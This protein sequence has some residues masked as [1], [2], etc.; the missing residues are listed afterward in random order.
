MGTIIV[1]CVDRD[2]GFW[3]RARK[4]ATHYILK[5]RYAVLLVP[6]VQLEVTLIGVLQLPTIR[7][8][9]CVCAFLDACLA[10]GHAPVGSE[11][12]LGLVRG[13]D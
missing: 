3:H 11:T 7:P 12:R 6:L 5:W 10:S 1:E 13:Q 2:L 8:E 9:L 4:F